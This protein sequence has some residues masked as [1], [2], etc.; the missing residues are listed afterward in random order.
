MGVINSFAEAAQKREEMLAASG[1]GNFLPELRLVNGEQATVRF[2]SAGDGTD[3]RFGTARVHAIKKI[4]K[5]GKRYAID[6]FCTAEDEGHCDLCDQLDDDENISK[7]TWR[8]AVWVWV[9]NILHLHQNPEPDEDEEEWVEVRTKTNKVYYREDIQAVKLFRKGYGQKGYL[10][11]M[12]QSFFEQFGTLDDRS[13]RISRKGADMLTTSYS[14]LPNGSESALDPAILKEAKK[15]PSIED[16]LRNRVGFD[17]ETQSF[18]LL[19]EP[20]ETVREAKTTRK[21]TPEPVEVAPRVKK[22][23]VAAED[24]DPMPAAVRKA[25]ERARAAVEAVEEASDDDLEVVAAT[26]E[27]TGALARL[28]AKAAGNTQP[29]RAAAPAAVAAEDE[30]EEYEELL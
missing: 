30:G 14:I 1:G 26:P 23:A 11:D 18:T 12:F 28:R 27:V 20:E 29:A 17:Q 8:F 10:F 25:T 22:R 24:A 13:Y 5:S 2:L 19:G 3:N 15:L 6:R 16:V 21:P 9:E 7:P 4:S